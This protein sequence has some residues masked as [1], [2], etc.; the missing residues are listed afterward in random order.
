MEPLKNMEGTTTH[1]QLACFNLGDTL[2]G[3]DIMRIREIL[4]PPPLSS[5]P[6]GSATLEGVINLRG[7]VIPVLNLRS[8]FK[9]PSEG[10]DTGGKLLIVSL[11]KQMLALAVD[12]VLEVITVPVAEMLPPIHTVAGIGME[13]VLGVTLSQN[14]VCMILDIDSLL[15]RPGVVA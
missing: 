3:V 8:F 10:R 9:M 6:A 5:L 14:R 1:I 13:Y 7:A 11:V 4:V 2:F 15:T 12:D